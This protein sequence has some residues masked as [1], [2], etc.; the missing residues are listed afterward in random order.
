MSGYMITVLRSNPFAISAKY[1][2]IFTDTC[3]QLW[4]DKILFSIKHTPPYRKKWS[5]FNP[6]N[7]KSPIQTYPLIFRNARKKFAWHHQQIFYIRT[8]YILTYILHTYIVHSYIYN[9]HVKL[10]ILTTNIIY[11][12]IHVCA[13]IYVYIY[14]YIYM[15][16]YIYVYTLTN[17]TNIFLQML[18]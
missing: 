7:L 14:V 15:C 17:L 1:L 9:I 18:N 4:R 2:Q 13:Y 6:L 11:P 3:I 5:K 16:I 8:L 12:H 10:Y